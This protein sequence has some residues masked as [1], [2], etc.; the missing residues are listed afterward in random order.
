MTLA[1]SH[2]TIETMI[3]DIQ[4]LKSHGRYYEAGALAASL[5]RDDFYGCHYGMRSQLEIARHQFRCGWQDA[6]DAIQVYG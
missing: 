6:A 4:T 1:A 2:Q 5:G 3:Q